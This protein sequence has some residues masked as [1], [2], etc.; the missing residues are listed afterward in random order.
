[1]PLRDMFWGAKFGMLTDAFGVH[2][3]VLIVSSKKPDAI[4]RRRGSDQ[5]DL[6]S[7]FE[8]NC[9]GRDVHRLTRWRAVS[10]LRHSP[11]P[12]SR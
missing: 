8:G 6:A 4:H 5:R 7:N 2:L 3:D 9:A 11:R 1:M 10:R 12:R